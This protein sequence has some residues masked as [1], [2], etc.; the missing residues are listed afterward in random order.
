MPFS[1]SIL[2]WGPYPPYRPKVDA[3]GFV[4]IKDSL[5]QVMSR[6]MHSIFLEERIECEQTIAL[7]F[8]YLAILL[9]FQQT[10]E[11]GCPVKVGKL[12]R[13]VL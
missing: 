3:V 7:Y 8:V 6:Q 11:F 1:L 5:P 4:L 13:V 10:W 12:F 9:L 2:H